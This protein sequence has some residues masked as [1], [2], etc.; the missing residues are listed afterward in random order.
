MK[1]KL[2][3]SFVVAV[4]IVAGAL[5][6]A[7]LSQRPLHTDEAVHAERYSR[8]LERGFYTYDPNEY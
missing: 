4:M 2:L 5:R 7:R 8:M 3:L 1:K 6:F